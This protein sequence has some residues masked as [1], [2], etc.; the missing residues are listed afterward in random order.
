MFSYGTTGSRTYG[1]ELGP[2]KLVVIYYCSHYYSEDNEQS[3]IGS[4]YLYRSQ[5]YV[6]YTSSS[7]DNRPGGIRVFKLKDTYNISD[8]IHT[9]FSHYCCS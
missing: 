3:S 9:H 1:L 8:S 5:Y 4:S 6:G 7:T 2:S